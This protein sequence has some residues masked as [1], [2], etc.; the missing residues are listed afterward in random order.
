MGL[1]NPCLFVWQNKP[2]AQLLAAQT[3]PSQGLVGWPN[4]PSR[5]DSI[6]KPAIADQ[7]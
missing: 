6:Q 3:G 5:L 1:C 7:G 2:G 4:G